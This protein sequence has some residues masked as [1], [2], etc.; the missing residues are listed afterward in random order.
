[1]E[2]EDFFSSKIRMK[3]LKMI[4][5][6]GELNVT[7]ISRKLGINHST[8]AKHLKILEDEG[9]LQHKMFGRIRL[10]RFDE[11]SLK[12]KALQNLIESWSHDMAIREKQKGKEKVY[13]IKSRVDGGKCHGDG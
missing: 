3:I 8:I 2:I 9:V 7:R 10:Y 5:Q 1:M 11:Q 4:L 6:R 13:P 12:A